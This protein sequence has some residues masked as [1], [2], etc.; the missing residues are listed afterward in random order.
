MNGQLI[1]RGA[2]DSAREA[3][4]YALLRR[5]FLG[6][7][8]ERFRADLAEK[9]WVLLLE[10]GR[11]RLVG[12]STLLLYEDREGGFSGEGDTVV[13]SG[14]TIVDPGAWG[15]PALARSWIRAV[16]GLHERWG[17]GRLWWLL[18]T[19]GFRT[20]RFLP[21]FCRDY[22]P[23]H[24]ASPSGELRARRDRLARRRFGDRYDPSTG[25][26][27]LRRPQRLR[28]GLREVPEGRLDDPHVALF[29]SLNPGH[30]EGDELVCLAELGDA[31]LTAAGLRMLY[32]A[33][34]PTKAGRRTGA[35]TCAA[36]A[37]R[38]G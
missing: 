27:R 21:V 31:N 22:H 17:A 25:I 11:G 12:F 10:D 14:D 26:V 5:H 4:M 29:A 18:I 30:A 20:Y 34:R 15:S 6:V 13:Y 38:A 37:K 35:A 28:P 7:D 19:S 16:R 3:A 23:Q 9:N 24:A 2:V 8:R 1:P 36:T 33:A 32:G